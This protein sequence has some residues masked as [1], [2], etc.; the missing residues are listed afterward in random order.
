MPRHLPR[1]VGLVVWALLALLL[2]H[3]VSHL[4]DEGL[5][6]SAGQLALVAIPQWLAIAGVVW[7][8]LRGEMLAASGAALLLGVGVA[9]GFAVIHLAPFALASYDELDPSAASVALAWVPLA[10]GLVL[11][12]LG[13]AALARAR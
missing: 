1:A 4:V 10:V 8:V 2:A 6:T 5:D 12:A 11:A 13:W 9:I 7:V 3:D